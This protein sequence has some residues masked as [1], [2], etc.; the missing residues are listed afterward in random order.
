MAVINLNEHE[1]P[2]YW[3]GN[4]FGCSRKN[5]QGLN[6]RFWLTEKGCYTRCSI[7]DHLC[8]IDGVV[9]GG[10]LTLLLEEVAQ[11][12][13]ISHFG[14]FGLTREISVRYLKPVPTNTE[15]LVEAQITHQSEKN[16]LFRSTVHSSEG[17][18]LTESESNWMFA[19]PAAISRAT[20]FDE[21]RLQEFLT[22][23]SKKVEG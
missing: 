17:K 14:K 21:S 16:I 3:T 7:P 18:L 2:N 8:G 5:T 9:H 13:I 23:Y 20:A 4:C 11:W 15:I 12:T 10:I 1:I 22:K 6:L 19:S